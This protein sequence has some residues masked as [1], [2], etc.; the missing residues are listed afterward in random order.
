MVHP[1]IRRRVRVALAT[2]LL[3]ALGE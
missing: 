3:Y 1:V 2:R